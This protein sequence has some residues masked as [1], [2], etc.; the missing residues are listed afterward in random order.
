MKHWKCPCCARIYESGDKASYVICKN[1]L[2][3]MKESPYNF[4][5]EKEVTGDGK[6]DCFETD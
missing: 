3:D 4:T 2:T 6:R 1:C 5:K